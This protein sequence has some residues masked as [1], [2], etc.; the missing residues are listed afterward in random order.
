MKKEDNSI[1]TGSRIKSGM[2]KREVSRNRKALRI[3]KQAARIMIRGGTDQE[4]FSMVADEFVG[5]GGIFIKFLQGILLGHPIM[6]DWNS[7]NKDKIFEK[8]DPADI[9]ITSLLQQ[10]LRANV[11]K[12]V[13]LDTKPF[14]AGSFGQAYMARHEDGKLVVVKALRPGARENLKKDLRLLSLV[15]MPLANKITTWDADLKSAERTFREATWGETDY[16]KEAANAAKLYK[17]NPKDSKLVIPRTYLELCTENVIIQEYIEGISVA[18]VIEDAKNSGLSHDEVVLNATGSNLRDQ[19][20]TLH[21]E[22]M[23]R[24]IGGQPVHGDTHPGN[25]K[26]LPDDKIG[27]IDFG[28]VVEPMKHPE[29]FLKFITSLNHGEYHKGG[30]GVVFVGYLEYLAYD[31]FKSI[32]IFSRRLNVNLNDHIGKLAEK[33]LYDNASEEEVETARSSVKF[34]TLINNR[35]NKNNRFN[36]LTKVDD[37]ALL[38]QMTTFVAMATML[39]HRE[40]LPEINENVIKHFESS[41]IKRRTQKEPTMERAIDLVGSWLTSIAEND[42]K[43]YQQITSALNQAQVT[44]EKV[45]SEVV[46]KTAKG[47]VFD[48]GRMRFVR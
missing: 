33:M 6:K 19:L 25:V 32:E 8:V 12:L 26:L 11:H 36:L 18:Q 34:G 17:F 7:A 31:L 5:M 20:M 13:E 2:T 16:V 29:R 47:P 3:A 43:L 39:E 23:T 46:A 9:D 10:Q 41:D 27:L 30:A 44:T 37:S 42:F 35:V 15:I 22:V 14:A 21:Q 24:A 40:I 1:I 4:M 45:V 28:I 48:F 38:R